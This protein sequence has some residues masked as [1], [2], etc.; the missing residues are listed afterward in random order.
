MARRDGRLR[1]ATPDGLTF[2]ETLLVT[3]PA[4]RI[5][6]RRRDGSLRNA[7]QAL[8]L[9]HGL[10]HAE[11]RIGPSWRARPVVLS[12]SALDRRPLLALAGSSTA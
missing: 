1:Q 7:A 9:R 5:D 11:L 8:G 6:A 3:C 10:I 12:C 2:E 4:C